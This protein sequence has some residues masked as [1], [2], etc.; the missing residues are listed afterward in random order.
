MSPSR[1]AVQAAIGMGG[2]QSI[3]PQILMPIPQT[4]MER[5]TKKCNS[6]NYILMVTN[7]S[8]NGLNASSAERKSWLVLEI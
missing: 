2:K 5:Y 4:I 6:G 1:S 7:S 8:L 3:D